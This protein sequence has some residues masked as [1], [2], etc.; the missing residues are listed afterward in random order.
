MTQPH[1]LL[2]LDIWRGFAVVLMIIY[3]FFFDLNHF[4]YVE[5]NFNGEWL[6]RLFRYFIISLFLLSVGI[7]LVLSHAKSMAFKQIIKR[8]LQLTT[9]S[10]LVSMASYLLFPATWIY[11]GILHFI[12]LASL[13]GLLFISFPNLSLLTA[14]IIWLTNMIGVLNMHWLFALLQPYL[15]LPNKTEDLVPFF[16]WFAMVLL[17]IFLAKQSYFSR[18][19]VAV[20]WTKFAKVGDILGVF[21]RHSLLIYLIHQ[22]LLFAMFWIKTFV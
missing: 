21:G 18:I 3:H 9:A 13:L 11:F 10:L 15:F 1:R 12:A 14:L 20:F 6:W 2:S 19:L 22:P 17:G 8:L 7:S 16:P 4:G 5:I